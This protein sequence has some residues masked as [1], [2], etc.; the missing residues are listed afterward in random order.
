[1]VIEPGTLSWFNLTRLNMENGNCNKNGN[2]IWWIIEN[3]H[4]I[5]KNAN[6]YELQSDK[7]LQST[8]HVMPASSTLTS[9]RENQI[10]DKDCLQS[11]I[12]KVNLV[13]RQTQR[14]ISRRARVKM[15]EQKLR[16][17]IIINY[18][19][20][21]RDLFFSSINCARVRELTAFCKVHFHRDALW[22]GPG[23]T[24][25]VWHG[26]GLKVGVI[27]GSCVCVCAWGEWVEWFVNCY[28]QQED[29]LRKQNCTIK[30]CTK[31]S[32]LQ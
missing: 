10:Q 20:Y 19:N 28:L 26:L 29:L 30:Q 11:F 22:P 13:M 5:L 4:L 18:C 7:T 12:F 23:E 21:F 25:P 6:E 2:T 8:K 1:M 24:C 16:Q 15:E 17:K 31:V 9:F 32:F 27:S 3:Y 14:G